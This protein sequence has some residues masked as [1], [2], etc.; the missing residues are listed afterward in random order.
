MTILTQLGLAVMIG[1]HAGAEPMSIDEAVQQAINQAF[2]VRTAEIDVEKADLQV[3]LARGALGLTVGA[4]ATYQRLDQ[5]TP[6]NSFPGLV[7]QNESKQ[8]QLQVNQAIDISGTSRAALAAARFNKEAA[9]FGVEAEVNLLKQIVRNKYFIVSQQKALVEVQRAEVA[10]AEERLEKARIREREEQIPKFDVLRLETDLKRAQQALF[11]AERNLEL[12]KQDLNNAIGRPINTEFEVVPIVGLPS[13]EAPPEEYIAV[14]M[15]ERPELQQGEVIIKSLEQVKETEKR[16]L[17]PSL[18]LSA[19]Y[20]N[21]LDPGF[22][23]SE[24]QT[25]GSAVLNWPL[26]DAGITK[27]RVQSAEKDVE[28]AEV[29]LEQS[30]LAVSFEVRS[31]LT[32]VASAYRSLEVARS[33]E[34]LAAEALRLAQLRYDEGIGTLLDVITAQAELTRARGATV[35]AFYTYLDAYAALQKAVGS[36]TFEATPPPTEENPQ[37]KEG[38]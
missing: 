27:S 28:K 3:K 8:L 17:K 19:V 29:Q 23:Q 12:A 34:E 20:T 2:A 24:H 15:I 31:A 9:E 6:P 25:V 30:K 37:K 22:G 5:S 11:D 7:T 18:N 38:N 36:D 33:A 4:N 1:A 35:N 26:F 10:A 16:G 32:R 21:N 13:L 14:A